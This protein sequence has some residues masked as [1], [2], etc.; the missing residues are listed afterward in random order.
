MVEEIL[1]KLDSIYGALTETPCYFGMSMETLAQVSES[2]QNEGMKEMIYGALPDGRIRWNYKDI[3]IFMYN[4]PEV[5]A[6][7]ISECGDVAT[8]GSYGQFHCFAKDASGKLTEVV[9]TDGL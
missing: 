7:K 4:R 6:A 1:V 2:F 3:P 5:I 9:S 8:P